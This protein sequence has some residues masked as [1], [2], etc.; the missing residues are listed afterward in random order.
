MN[1]SKYYKMNLPVNYKPLLISTV[2]LLIAL[3]QPHNCDAQFLKKVMSKAQ[4]KL[5]N[6]IE[7]ELSEKIANEIA[8]RLYKPID[9][10]FEDLWT[11]SFPKDS[12][13][14]VDWEALD[15]SYSEMML[16]LDKSADL[17]E[18]YTYDIALE[19][20]S[21][22]FSGDKSTSIMYLSKA[23]NSMAIKQLESDKKAVNQLV[24]IDYENDIIAMYDTEE[25]TGQAIGNMLGMAATI[26][27]DTENE[28]IIEKT[29]K[30]KSLL[31]YKCQEYKSESEKEKMKFYMAEDFPIDWK[32]SY[33]GFMEKFAP[34]LYRD[35]LSKIEGMI[36]KSETELKSKKKKSS[37]K[38]KEIDEQGMTIQN[39]NYTFEPLTGK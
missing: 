25:K 36:L 37:W 12:T 11:A 10:A 30:S 3:L 26:A 38:V 7:D 14:Q 23:G 22:D 4:D 18:S 34:N 33:N 32:E 6:R 28:M 17:P 35:N 9:A 27:I 19:I 20:E 5:E 1:K 31:D 24:V 13:G 8:A 29:G 15:E 39:S 2:F 21:K 16:A